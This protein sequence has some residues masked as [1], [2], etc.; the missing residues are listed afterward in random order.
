VRK[1]HTGRIID[2]SSLGG[3]I[4]ELQ[5]AW[6]HVTKFAVEGLSDSLRMELKEADKPG[7]QHSVVPELL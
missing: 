3:S 4:G 7:A 1:E 6:Y 2:I 5:G